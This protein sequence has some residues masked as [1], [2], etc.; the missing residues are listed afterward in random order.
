MVE[1]DGRLPFRFGP[2]YEAIFM[3]ELGGVMRGLAHAKLVPEN[4]YVGIS[5]YV[6]REP[7]AW[8]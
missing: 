8:V 7:R 3:V 6:G 4:M 5:T 2:Y 1:Y